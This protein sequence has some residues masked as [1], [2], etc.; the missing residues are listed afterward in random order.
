MRRSGGNVIL[1]DPDWSREET[2]YLLDL[3]DTFRLRFVHVADRYQVR[4]L[5][6]VGQ[7][8]QS[9]VIS[10]LHLKPAWGAGLCWAGQ[11]CAG[12]AA[13]GVCSVSCAGCA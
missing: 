4:C 7:L 1:P 8:P 10:A 9:L 12:R 11:C 2:D 3:C 6:T 13:V 5:S